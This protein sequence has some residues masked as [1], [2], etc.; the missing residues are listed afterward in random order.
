MLWREWSRRALFR[1]RGSIRRHQLTPRMDVVTALRE[2][3]VIRR[4][5]ADAAQHDGRPVEAVA[6]EVDGYLHEMVPNFSI[7]AYGAV[8]YTLARWISR[9]LYRLTVHRLPSSSSSTIAAGRQDAVVYFANHRSNAD[10]VLLTA[11]LGHDVQISYAAG[12]WARIWPL[13]RLFRR[14]GS[15]FVRRGFPDP[16]YHAVLARYV[17]TITRQGV[18]QGVFPEGGLTRDGALRPPKLGLLDTMLSVLCDPAFTGDVVLVP[19]GINYDRVLEDRTLLAERSEGRRPGKLWQFAS[20]VSFLGFNAFRLITGQYR[21]YGE[22]AVAIGAPLAVRRWLT[23]HG[24]NQLPATREAR[25]P[26]VRALAEDAMQRVEKILPVTPV[27]LAAAALR[28]LSEPVVSEREV[29][30][31]I[32]ALLVRCR[33]EGRVLARPDLDAAATW[34]RAKRM[35]RARWLVHCHGGTVRLIPEAA[36]MLA[37]YANTVVV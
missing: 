31:R 6:R 24:I 14:F 29:E 15:Y 34:D 30:A 23:D 8:A 17:S 18:V 9:I 21:R 10:A 5:I 20:V 22:A 35:L 36:S 16:L 19:V 2:D 1:W 37:Y 33:A 25:Q 7:V 28:S 3:P 12:E 26:V 32:A 4:A 11:I 27:P 13:D